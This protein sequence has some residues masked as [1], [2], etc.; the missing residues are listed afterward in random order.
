M[1]DPITKTVV[2]RAPGSAPVAYPI[3]DLSCIIRYSNFQPVFINGL[4]V[5][6]AACRKVSKT[7]VNMFFFANRV[8]NIWNSLPD[9]I[10]ASPSVAYFKRK[11]SKFHFNE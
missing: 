11:L 4:V 3:F 6:T 1:A 2:T 5:S 8:I 7:S 9:H 10:V